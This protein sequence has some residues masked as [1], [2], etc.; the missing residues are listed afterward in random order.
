MKAYPR[1]RFCQLTGIVR[2]VLHRAEFVA[3]RD[4]KLSYRRETA[5]QLRNAYLGWLTDRAMHRTPRNRRGCIIFWH[6][7]ALL[8]SRSAGRKRILTWNSHSSLE[9]IQGHYFMQSV[10]GRRG[11]ASS[12]NIA[13]RISDVFEDVATQIAKNCCRRQPHSHLT[14]PPKETPANIPIH[15]IFPETKI[16]GLHFCR[17]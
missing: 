7:N 5:R 16:I 15:V 9:V 1:P 2:A 12:Y 3:V 13:C 10:T 11:V 14:P 4:K 8:D 6:S 17:W